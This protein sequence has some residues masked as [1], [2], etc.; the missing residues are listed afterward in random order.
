MQISPRTLLLFVV[1]L[2]VLGCP[3]LAQ[4]SEEKRDPQLD[5]QLWVEERF[6]SVL[7]EFLSFEK[8]ADVSFRTYRDLYTNVLEYSCSITR[9]KDHIEAVVKLAYPIS[10]YDQIMAEHKKNPNETIKS[11]K[12]KLTVKEFRFSNN[13]CPAVGASLSALEKLQLPVMTEKERASAANGVVE[14]AL[15]PTIYTFDVSISGGS[16]RLELD[17]H[18][19]PLVRWADDTRRALEQCQQ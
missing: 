5:L 2:C 7:N 18:D 4:Q 11:I 8:D 16:A 17:S 3:V 9:R 10:L 13:T 19:H 14:V 1:L 6:P 12:R 15:H